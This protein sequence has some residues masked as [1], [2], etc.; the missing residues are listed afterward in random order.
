[1][2]ARVS[3]SAFSGNA[4]AA[5]IVKSLAASSTRR[6]QAVTCLLFTFAHLTLVSKTANGSVSKAIAEWRPARA[7]TAEVPDPDMGSKTRS[8][9]ESSPKACRGILA[10]ILA[11]NGWGALINCET[12]RNR[13]GR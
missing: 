2:K 7:T 13:D 4:P 9:R 5:V 8:D 1:M 3:S 10:A 6:A 11:G 12:S